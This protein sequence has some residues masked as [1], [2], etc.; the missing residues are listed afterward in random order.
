LCRVGTKRTHYSTGATSMTDRIMNLAIIGAGRIA[1]VH[2]AAAA[3]DPRIK[4]VY[5]AD[6]VA[7]AAQA[8]ATSYGASVVD[9]DAVFA[10]DAIDAVLIAS[11][12]ATHAQFMEQ[13]AR[14]GKAVLCEKPIALDLARTRSA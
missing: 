6:I 7:D 1:R 2:A 8:L 11:S 9:A 13:A 5:V 12:T 3:R 14:S 10:D 4:L